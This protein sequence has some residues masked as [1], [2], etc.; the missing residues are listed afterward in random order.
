V[1]VAAGVV[2]F[3]GAAI[4]QD[5]PGKQPS[6]QP[7]TQGSQG[8]AFEQCARACN[9]CGRSCGACGAHCA[10]LIAKGHK[11]HLTTLKACQD[12]GTHCAAAACITAR[13]GPF[14]DLICKVCAEACKRCGDAC[15]QHKHDAI[16]RRCAEECRRCE[17]AC[18]EMLKHTGQGGSRTGR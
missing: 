5:R 17:Q 15:E 11:E 6:N 10:E 14:S 16:M 1:F 8:G 13:Q 3:L 12:C 7:A 9:D 2:A 18:R 4:A